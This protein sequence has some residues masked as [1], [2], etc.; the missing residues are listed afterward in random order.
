MQ[1]A[2]NS[3][4]GLIGRLM[5]SCSL[6]LIAIC[7][8]GSVHAQEQVNG[9][10]A[11]SQPPSV[12]VL[13]TIVVTAQRR[14][15]QFQDVPLSIAAYSG[16]ALKRENITDTRQLE[17]ISPSLNYGQGTSLKGGAFNLR[18]VS[19]Q[20]TGGGVQPSTAMVL[21][22]VPL[23]RPGEFVSAL[24]DIQ[25]VEVLNGPQGTLFGKNATAGVISI[26]TNR[27]TDRFE[28]E[29]SASYT[30][31]DELLVRGVLNVPLTE[32]IRTR[33]AAYYNNLEPLIK[34]QFEGGDDW[35][36][37]KN[38]GVRAKVEF[39]LGP[40]VELLLTGEYQRLND[41]FTLYFPINSSTGPGRAALE[42]AA[43]GYTA[44]FGKVINNTDGYNR[45]RG[46]YKNV[47]AELNWDINDK[48]SLTSISSYRDAKFYGSSGDPDM[49]PL[50]L[51][52]GRNT[53]PLISPF[54]Q[55]V[56]LLSRKLSYSTG[57]QYFTQ[58]TR[59]NYGD[60][61][62][63]AV[64]GL[65]FQTMTE[66]S[67]STFPFLIYSGIPGYYIYANSTPQART[68]NDTWAAFGDLTW[69][70]TD[71]LSLFGG[72]RYTHE[73]IRT[74]YKNDVWTANSASGVAF[75]PGYVNPGIS[76]L[77]P[78][79]YSNFDPVTG[80][81]FGPGTFYDEVTGGIV[82]LPTSTKSFDEN[83]TTNNLSGRIGIQ[84]QPTSDQ[85]YYFSYNRGYKGGA[86]DI[87]RGAQAP[88]PALGTTPVV[89]PEKAYSFELGTKLSLFKNRVDVSLNLYHQRIQNVQQTVLTTISSGTQL[90]NAGKLKLDGGEFEVRALLFEG[91]VVNGSVAYNDARYGGTLPNGELPRV[92]C[93]PGQT[94]DQGCT[95]PDG[96]GPRGFSTPIAGNRAQNAPEWKFNVG[97]TYTLDTPSLPFN[98]VTSANYNW[99]DAIQFNLNNDPTTIQPSHGILN[100]SITL[101]DQN[102][103]WEF[104]IFARNLTNEFY[105]SGVSD[106]NNQLARTFG[107]LGRDYKR[108][109]GARLTV[110]F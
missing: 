104:Q 19:S 22:G 109:G 48:T 105:Y 93:Y 53:L 32:G 100:A 47:T 78:T 42:D 98:I 50:G 6:G 66:D 5:S 110:K 82:P 3:N 35:G 16:E 20:T 12:K 94:A 91:L 61:Q 92:G 33:V 69:H 51:T 24:G 89:A 79:G 1:S 62:F 14:E 60:E 84:W 76:A 17:Q 99:V 58:E 63:D 103:R 44:A 71:T 106:A 28:G 10:D 108:Y 52:P 65:F 2:V 55:G 18:G 107:F 56:T 7:G 41:G 86:I 15:Q 49:S 57:P 67:T 97:A 31:D 45:D 37:R 85:N 68:E 30:T 23:L 102:D 101:V 26:I 9:K 90:L 95:D 39:D 87:A 96:A 75:L 21:D 70:A 73:T 40:D 77:P 88:N 43:R 27:P 13:D 34:N 64:G 8:A 59:I 11:A 25:R 74:R 54:V 81:F 38:Y 83:L 46:T 4:I 80:D 29:V 36:S 72:L